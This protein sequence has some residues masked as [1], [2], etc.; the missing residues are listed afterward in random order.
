MSKA[1]NRADTSKWK[2][3]RKDFHGD[4]CDNAKCAICTPHKAVGG[5]SRKV[6]KAK[7]I[8]ESQRLAADLDTMFYHE[9]E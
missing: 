8:A 9:L 1:Q 6:K 2:K 4:R 5:N 3:K 7:D